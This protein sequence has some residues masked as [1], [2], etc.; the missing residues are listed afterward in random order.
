M[1]SSKKG[2][3]FIKAYIY[4]TTALLLLLGGDPK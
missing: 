2:K 1:I 4:Y 3:K